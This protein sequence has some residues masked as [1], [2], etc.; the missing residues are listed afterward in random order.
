MVFHGFGVQIFNGPAE[1]EKVRSLYARKRELQHLAALGVPLDREERRLLGWRS[2][3]VRNKRPYTSPTRRNQPCSL[4]QEQESPSAAEWLRLERPS[5]STSPAGQIAHLLDERHLPGIIDSVEPLL[6]TSTARGRSEVR[7][8]CDLRARSWHSVEPALNLHTLPRQDSAL[9]MSDSRPSTTSATRNRCSSV[10]AQVPHTRPASNIPWEPQPGCAKARPFPRIQ[11]PKHTNPCPQLAQ[12]GDVEHSKDSLTCT[13]SIDAVNAPNEPS[14]STTCRQ[15]VA[16]DSIASSKTSVEEKGQGSPVPAISCN[17]IPTLAIPQL[18]GAVS[19]DAARHESEVLGDL[20]QSQSSTE[21]I[22]G[23]EMPRH[24]FHSRPMYAEQPS[25]GSNCDQE[26]R[27]PV[28]EDSV[29]QLETGSVQAKV[30]GMS[31]EVD[32]SLSLLMN[33][34]DELSAASQVL[35]RRASSLL[36]QPARNSR[37]VKEVSTRRSAG[38]DEHPLPV[39]AQEHDVLTKDEQH[40][41]SD[42]ISAL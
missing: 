39:L 19:D 24:T 6:T 42:M 3:H 31:E 5:T 11:Q 26:C 16:Q 33:C 30:Q 15:P 25:D 21:G 14:S 38:D 13:G 20:S 7:F 40:L 17:S 34:H 10:P 8:E 4:S 2:S 41:L 18:A 28:K 1:M 23:S 36:Q 9:Y 35:M 37:E 27:E 22:R 29:P 32:T 12:D